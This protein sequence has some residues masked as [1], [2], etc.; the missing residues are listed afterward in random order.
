MA[1]TDADSDSTMI[2]LRRISAMAV[3]NDSDGNNQTVNY[4]DFIPDE[5]LKVTIQ[6]G[7]TIYYADLKYVGEGLFAGSY[8]PLK[9]GQYSVNVQMGGKDIFC[10]LGESNKCSPFSLFVEP[11]PV[12]ALTSEIESP[13]VSK[14]DYLVEAAAGEYGTLFIQAKD[15]FGNNR[16]TGGDAFEVT[17]T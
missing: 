14:L 16:M 15:A 4:E 11:G 2:S 12:V 8:I 9:S 3:P 1:I 10:G 7:K 17:F 6:S 13:A 5:L